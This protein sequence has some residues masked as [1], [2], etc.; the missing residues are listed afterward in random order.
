MTSANKYY[1]KY[2]TYIKPIF[3]NLIVKSY[4]LPALNILAMLVFIFTAIKPTVE[5]ITIL[6]KKIEDSQNTL[7]LINKKGEDLIK[8][9][10]NL[11]NMSLTIRDKINTSVPVSPEIRSIIRTL[12][13][14]AVANQATISA[15]KFEPVVFEDKP[16]GKK[17]LAEV[18]FSYNIE[19]EYPVLIKIINDL[20]AGPRLISIESIVLNKLSEGPSLLMAIKGK[21]YFLK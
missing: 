6:Q 18:E 14:S 12:E 8:G 19:G 21:A 16:E 15:L 3:R 4:S 1:S 9:K 13:Q 2:F 20:N 17:E 7:E 5:T 10:E 11:E